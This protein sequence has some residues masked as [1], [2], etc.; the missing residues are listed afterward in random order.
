MDEFPV[1]DPLLA[2]LRNARPTSDPGDPA[3]EAEKRSALLERLLVER[4]TDATPAINPSHR[5]P[6]FAAAA[7]AVIIAATAGIVAGT[8]GA[9]SKAGR[10]SAARAV[11]LNA[12][13]VSYRARTAIASQ[14][15]DGI[16]YT[17]TTQP[18]GNVVDT[19]QYEGSRRAERFATG[20]SP[21][22]DAGITDD[23]GTVSYLIVDYSKQTFYQ[24][25]WQGA[26]P[27]GCIVCN[28]KAELAD[29]VFKVVTQTTLNGQPALEL[30][31]EPPA[32]ATGVSKN[33]G[34][35]T[36][37]MTWTLW[38]DPTT[39]LPIQSQQTIGSKGEDDT[40]YEWLEPDPANLA[41]LTVP[42]PSGFTQTSVGS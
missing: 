18:N 40:T 4:R 25:S 6:M 5:R 19:W 15:A 21:V 27:L 29:G 39:Y 11:V 22:T 7:A 35:A 41:Q 8:S 36:D 10:P 14:D 23:S 33:S 34:A 30:S 38:V 24:T 12:E 31:Y 28:I 32:A 26:D 42:V 17:Q 9:G 20:G 16:D 2:A 13:T 3:V 1:S 37:T